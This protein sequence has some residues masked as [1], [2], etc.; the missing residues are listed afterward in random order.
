MLQ[1]LE[2][3]DAVALPLSSKLDSVREPLSEDN[4]QKSL[5]VKFV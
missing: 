1:S 2:A 4:A 5:S 3:S